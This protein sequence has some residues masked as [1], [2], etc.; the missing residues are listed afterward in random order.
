[1]QFTR[2]RLYANIPDNYSTDSKLQAFKIY[3]DRVE[4]F[5]DDRVVYK[6]QII[7]LIQIVKP[8]QYVFYY[9]SKSEVVFNKRILV[10]IIIHIITSSREFICVS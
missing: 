1:M 2:K 7:V 8:N 3:F 4:K 5:W 9:L 6:V 10:R